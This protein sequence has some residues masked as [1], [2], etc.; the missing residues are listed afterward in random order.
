ME[1]AQ[2]PEIGLDG[3]VDRPTTIT[4]VLVIVI[5]INMAT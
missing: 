1:A 5:N 2:T 3:V 4:A